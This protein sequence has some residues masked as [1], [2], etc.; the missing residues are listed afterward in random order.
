MP[1]IGIEAS[2]IALAEGRIRHPQADLR[3]WRAG[4]P[5]PCADGS[6]GVTM[7]NQV[8]DHFTLEENRLLFDDL[9]RVLKPGGVLIA[10]SPSR[11]N[12]FDTDTGHVTFFS[13]LEFRA[14]V[15]DAGFDVI[16]QPFVPQPVLGGGV[17]W[18]VVRVFTHFFKPQRMAATIDIVAVKR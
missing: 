13:P 18:R 10:H 9:R 11:F 8:I 4:T 16:A 7:L 6:I 17:G 12:R 1:A 5:L 3:Q 2:D 15:A 14:F